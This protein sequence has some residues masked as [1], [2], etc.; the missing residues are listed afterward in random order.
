MDVSGLVQRA[1]EL[2]R[3][4]ADAGDQRCKHALKVM[5]DGEPW[6]H[7]RQRV[8]NTLADALDDEDRARRGRPAIDDSKLLASVATIGG[9]HA[10]GMVTRQISDRRTRGTTAR[11]LR[12]KRR[13]A[14]VNQ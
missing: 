3:L 12:E 4:E 5:L 1:I 2:L 14:A 7:E 13:K 10:I 8:A 11:R 9:P 6:Q